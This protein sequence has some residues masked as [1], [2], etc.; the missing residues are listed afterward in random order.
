MSQKITINPSIATILNINWISI[1][2]VVPIYFTAS[3]NWINNY[4]FS[5]WSSE[6]KT[7]KIEIENSPISISQNVM[8]LTLNPIQQK[9]PAGKFYYEITDNTSKRIIF[10]GEINIL[11]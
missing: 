10:K 1:H 5:I 6:D 7:N 8:T 9:I 4:I 3:T 11:N 2:E